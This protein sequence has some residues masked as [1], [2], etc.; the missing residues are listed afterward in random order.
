MIK[1]ERKKKK[2]NGGR[3]EC[4]KPRRLT[5]AEFIPDTSF[6]KSLGPSNK[7]DGACRI[8]MGELEAS[9]CG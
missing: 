7:P 2:K 8:E 5:Q 4:R 9:C 6:C 1:D 3:T